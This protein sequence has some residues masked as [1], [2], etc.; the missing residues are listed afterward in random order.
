MYL[1]VYIDMEG[2]KALVVGLGE[3]GTRRA[4]KLADAGA[5]VK[6]FDTVDKEIE[7]VE[8]V[9]KK[10]SIDSL[11]ELSNFFLVVAST[12]DT[13]LNRRIVEE[14]SQKGVVASCAGDFNKGDVVFPGFV[15]RDN[16]KISITTMGDNPFLTKKIK[17]VLNREISDKKT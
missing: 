8:T 17:D 3:V 10:I 9:K 6:G 12:D 2:K 7:G 13:D 15:Y 14:A 5:D 16:E 4:K 11:P 1:P